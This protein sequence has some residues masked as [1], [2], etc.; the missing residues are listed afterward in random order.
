MDALFRLALVELEASN[1]RRARER[2]EQGL[3]LGAGRDVFTANLYLAHGRALEGLGIDLEAAASYHRALGSPRRSSGP[4]S[5]SSRREIGDAAS[6]SP[7]H[8]SSPLSLC[9]CGTQPA[10]AGPPLTAPERET[11]GGFA[12][13]LQRVDLD[14]GQAFAA[15]APDCNRAC[16]LRG[17]ICALAERICGIADRHPGDLQA[18]ERCRDARE[19]CRRAEERVGGRC[20]CL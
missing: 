18:R 19:R 14:F 6:R 5:T 11:L 17:H 1:P 9:A 16:L 7:P 2:A 12:E 4:R 15:G 8:P 3:A 20:R 10:P 13:A